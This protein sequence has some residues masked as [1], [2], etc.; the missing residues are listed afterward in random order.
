[1]LPSVVYHP[2]ALSALRAA[3]I[4]I[5]AMVIAGLSHSSRELFGDRG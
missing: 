2:A 3:T 4:D 5:N 1:M